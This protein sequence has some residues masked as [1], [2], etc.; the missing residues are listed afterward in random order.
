MRYACIDQYE[1]EH[2]MEFSAIIIGDEILGGMRQDKH[3]SLA[4]QAL[5]KCGL[6]LAWA[7]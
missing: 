1:R 7:E 2:T 5:A 6:R 4:I 3:M